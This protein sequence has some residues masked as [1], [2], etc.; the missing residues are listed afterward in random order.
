[1]KINQGFSLIEMAVVLVIIGILIGGMLTVMAEQTNRQRIQLTQQRLEE[2]KGALLGFAVF[3]RRLPCPA[4]N[5]LGQEAGKSDAN[6][7]VCNTYDNAD[8]YLPWA[9]LGVEKNDAWGRPFRYRVDGWFSD[10]SGIYYTNTIKPGTTKELLT[11]QTRQGN[12]LNIVKDVASALYPNYD[13]RSNLVAIIFSC[14]N[15]GTPDDQNDAD[16]TPNNDA[17][18]TN[19]GPAGATKN[20]Y[21]QDTYV[22]DQFDDILLT[23]PKS[24]LIN[25]LAAAGNW[26]PP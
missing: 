18:C 3:K 19:P 5:T 1:M 11:L 26:P 17:N 13:Y 8:G 10:D 23:L 20:I 7:R 25:R 4:E 2:I 12:I 6:G 14:G 22:E 24:L 9:T 21:I 16:H 15:N